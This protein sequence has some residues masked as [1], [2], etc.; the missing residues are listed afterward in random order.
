[1]PPLISCILANL[2]VLRISGVISSNCNEEPIQC[3]FNNK[4]GMNL[5][6]ASTAAFCILQGIFEL[7]SEYVLVA[8]W[9]VLRIQ[10]DLRKPHTTRLYRV[11]LV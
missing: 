10:L 6:R 11:C 7:L 9:I 3:V 1:M 8:L 2:K 4:L 5:Y